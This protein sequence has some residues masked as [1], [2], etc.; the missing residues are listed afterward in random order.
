MRDP[1]DIIIPVYKNVALVKDC[2]ESLRRNLGEIAAYEPRIV[3]IN[4]SPDD[5]P[6]TEYLAA[7]KRA[8]RIDILISN[9]KNVGFVR[10]VNK[11]IAEA[12]MRGAHAILV[13]S[14]T[15]TFEN[16]LAEMVGVLLLD[17]QIGFVSP[18]SNNAS[19]CTFPQTPHA[20]AGTTIDPA[21]CHSVWASVAHHLPRYTF[22]PT[23]VGFYM[24]I[25]SK[26]LDD[27]GGLDE[28]FDVGYEEENDLVLRANKVGF[29][30][31]LANHAFAY[32]AGSA[33]FLLRDID[34]TEHRSGNLHKMMERHP[35]FLP[36]VMQYQ[37]SA[38]Y[39]AEQM[40]RNLVRD[41]AGRLNLVVNLLSMGPAFNG[42]N[43]LILNVLKFLNECATDRFNI[44]LLAR[45]NVAS[46][47]GFEQFDCLAW[48]EE[49]Q[50]KYAI[51]VSFG[52]PYDLHSINIMEMLAPINVYGMLD[53][54]SWDCGYLRVEQQ[55]DSLWNYVAK[56]ANGLMY[57]SGFSK[58]I[59]ERSFPVSAESLA[60]SRLLPTKVAAYAERY[61][62]ARTGARHVFVAGNHFKHKDSLRAAKQLAEALPSLQFVVLGD[63]SEQQHGN[64]INLQAGNVSDEDMI[65]TIAEASVVVLPSYYE[66]FGFSIMHAL[67]LGKPV[68]ARDIPSTREILKSFG[69]VEGVILFKKN[70][71]MPAAITAAVQARKSSVDDSKADDWQDWAR[72][73]ADFLNALIDSPHVYHLLEERITQGDVIRRIFDAERRLRHMES[74]RPHV[75]DVVAVAHEQEARA[76]TA[77]ALADL[78][79]L[80]PG[81]FVDFLYEHLLG[82]K[83]DP[84][85]YNHHLLLLEQGTT[86]RDMLKSILRSGEY[87][88]S[89]RQ[90]KV[91]GL[92]LPGA[93]SLKRIFGFGK[94]S[95]A[96]T[97]AAD[98]YAL[99]D[100]E[101]MDSGAF[102][103]FL[104]E[105]L[106]GRKADPT[107]YNHH[108]LLLEE[109]TTRRDMLKSIL[110]SDEYASSGRDVRVTGLDRPIALILK[111]MFG[112][113]KASA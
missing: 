60:Y 108:L 61:A 35:E 64:I 103:D 111:R 70:S 78:E 79:A 43:E 28:I 95:A 72:G 37:A 27:F 44:T 56:S 16:T 26:I 34:L 91:S 105:R 29:R 112:T 81:A 45:A 98:E 10:S 3:V 80:D 4:D 110:R 74:S 63:G 82:R 100:L 24:L 30:S 113:R 94:A 89:G 85:G 62:N 31:V 33:S 67:A 47:H 59:F 18:R 8:G 12:R 51:A 19:I 106:L 39:R 6:V 76:E 14:D 15:V 97:Q 32:H 99:A 7:A 77:Y 46:F 40:L 90:V 13:N 41:D 107:G 25:K 53:V 101:A 86:R 102:V 88:S 96:V 109:G 73:F 38:K 92:G 11:G 42:T 69:K 55:I 20:L 93:F 5:Q 66:G 17:E 71:D 21:S 58:Q 9:E 84:T 49:V 57:I 87:T 23:A 1:I 104:Y 22:T 52:Q 50:S 83:A 54:I 2:L 36:L 75:P 68:V 65:A 48:T